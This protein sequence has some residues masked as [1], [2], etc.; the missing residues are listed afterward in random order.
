M[1]DWEGW[2]LEEE[3]GILEIATVS[4]P[5][6]RHLSQLLSHA[7]P[8]P[9]AAKASLQVTARAVAS[10]SSPRGST[11]DKNVKKPP[12]RAR[13]KAP[14]RI[15]RIFDVLIQAFPTP[16][17][18]KRSCGA[19]QHRGHSKYLPHR[20]SLNIRHQLLVT[21]HW[22]LVIA[23]GLF[24]ISAIVVF[25]PVYWASSKLWERRDG[26]E[27]GWGITFVARWPVSVTGQL[28]S[29]RRFFY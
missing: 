2:F 10:L 22:S 9:V 26:S 5:G 16:E 1:P 6:G 15:A 13:G 20:E 24:S 19:P 29:A 7:P 12:R 14:A 25:C 4:G 3:L 28:I 18:P 21:G 27:K 11:D 8:Y 17:T 23:N